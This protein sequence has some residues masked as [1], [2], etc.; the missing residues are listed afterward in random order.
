MKEIIVLD[1]GSVELLIKDDL[2]SVI[3]S[4]IVDEFICGKTQWLLPFKD[5]NPIYRQLKK[6][7]DGT[8]LACYEY[9]LSD[10]MKPSFCC[11]QYNKI[12]PC[13]KR[14]EILYKIANKVSALIYEATPN[15]CKNHKRGVNFKA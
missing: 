4:I 5:I 13:E 12:K 14:R 8:V 7:T 11:T 15:K 6:E 2:E 9:K 10:V 1:W 3:V